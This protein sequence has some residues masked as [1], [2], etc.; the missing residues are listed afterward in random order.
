MNPGAGIIL[1]QTTGNRYSTD[2][3]LAL[4]KQ[5]GAIC[6][7][8]PLRY[9]Y[10]RA[11]ARVCVCGGGGGAGVRMVAPARVYVKVADYPKT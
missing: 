4:I 11:H 5:I 2:Y 8:D 6:W 3:A 9:A 7:Y 1:K 10:R